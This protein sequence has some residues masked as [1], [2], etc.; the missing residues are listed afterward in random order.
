[1]FQ[2]FKHFFTSQKNIKRLIHCML[3]PALAF[4]SL[5][6]FAEGKD[7]LAGT[8]EDL[9]KTVGSSGKTYLYIAEM[10]ICAASF[11]KTRNPLV[12]AGVLI[13][14]VGFNVIFKIAG[15]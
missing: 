2:P 4:L 14:A 10:I 8:S 12:F 9:I 6:C 5:T 15:I 3:F 7:L 13:L 1:M 11:I